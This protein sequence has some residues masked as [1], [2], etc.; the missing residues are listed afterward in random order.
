MA[1]TCKSCIKPS[2][3]CRRRASA[4]AYREERDSSMAIVVVSQVFRRIGDDQ[5]DPLS[6]ENKHQE[7]E[8][9]KACIF[10]ITETS[11]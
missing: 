1:S 3:I 8:E 5:I 6:H 7:I 11:R 4:L 2:S 9:S 10:T